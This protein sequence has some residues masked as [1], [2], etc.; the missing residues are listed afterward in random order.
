[1]NSLDFPEVELKVIATMVLYLGL[2]PVF[3]MMTLPDS[4]PS[5]GGQA[6]GFVHV[7]KAV[8]AIRAFCI[9]YMLRLM[10]SMLRFGFPT[11]WY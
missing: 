9:G 8:S 4:C 2:W 6:Q 1:M 10:L 7:G 3:M 5:A 11:V